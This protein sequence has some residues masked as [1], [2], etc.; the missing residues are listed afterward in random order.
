VGIN[1][2]RSGH[3]TGER[4]Y[5]TG[6]LDRGTPGWTH[7]PTTGILNTAG[8][9][10][11][12]PGAR[13]SGE[14]ADDY[15]TRLHDQGMD[16]ESIIGMMNGWGTGNVVRRP[17]A[18]GDDS[19]GFANAPWIDPADPYASPSRPGY[20][21]NYPTVSGGAYWDAGHGGGAFGG[22]YHGG[23][24]SVGGGARSNDLTPEMLDFFS[25]TPRF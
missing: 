11:A 8:M 3:G 10:G 17:G 21:T 14:T 15:I 24:A 9:P 5:D 18:G 7:D 19:Y 23:G 20:D 25:N 22:E 16:M 1:A 12:T 6:F 4:G 2:D 13:R